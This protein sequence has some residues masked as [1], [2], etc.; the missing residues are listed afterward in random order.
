M[1][2]RERTLVVVGSGEVEKRAHRGRD[3]D[4]ADELQVIGVDDEL[5]RPRAHARPRRDTRPDR[6]GE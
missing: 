4:T 3:E 5:A 2:V 1:Q 6:R